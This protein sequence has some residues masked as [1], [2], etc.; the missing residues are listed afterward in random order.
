VLLA[1]A[2]AASGC[3]GPKYDS[4]LQ[5]A[6]F[7]FGEVLDGHMMRARQAL[8]AVR[9][10]ESAKKAAATLEMINQDLDDVAYNAYRLS[11]EG[12]AQLGKLAAGHLAE[13]EGLAREIRE[14]PVLWDVL[15]GGLAG[16]IGELG[17]IS[18]KALL[19]APG[20]RSI[21][22]AVTVPANEVGILS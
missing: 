15:G 12:Q 6:E 2:L 16:M 1:V 20:L 17:G 21:Q 4:S 5:L 14:R 8:G 3:G 13:I 11:P 19:K 22:V 9:D 7:N 10:L 18:G